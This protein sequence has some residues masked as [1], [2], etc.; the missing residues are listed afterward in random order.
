MRPLGPPRRS[1]AGC[2][3][4]A[5]ATHRSPRRATPHARTRTRRRR[6]CTS[7]TWWASAAWTAAAG[8]ARAGWTSASIAPTR[9]TSGSSAREAR[10]LSSTAWSMTSTQRARRIATT[11]RARRCPT[12]K[13]SSGFHIG[14]ASAAH[15][16]TRY[17]PRRWTVASRPRPA[18][19][20][21][22]RRPRR[23]PA[24]WRRPACARRRRGRAATIARGVG[25]GSA[26]T[27]TSLAR[28]GPGR[29]R[30]CLIARTTS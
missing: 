4:A 5:P 14:A 17:G 16:L 10:G 18:R 8:P 13:R 9:P 11:R 22:S 1:W 3:P 21:C 26:P 23:R 25:P 19:W 20:T 27:V 12:L 30:T 29:R 24:Y 15:G 28:R 7:T 6:R 2:A